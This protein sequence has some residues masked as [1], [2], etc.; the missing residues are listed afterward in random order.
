[1]AKTCQRLVIG[2]GRIE[3]GGS[4]GLGWFRLVFD[5]E[6]VSRTTLLGAAR[7]GNCPHTI[8]R[9]QCCEL[10]AAS[11]R[12][13]PHRL[14]RA[15]QAVTNTEWPRIVSSLYCGGGGGGTWVLK[16]ILPPAGPMPCFTV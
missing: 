13:I 14:R 10:Q 8:R 16:C 11:G 6:R 9:V 3:G 7:L 15:T 1:M 12:S 4:L 2:S 5:T